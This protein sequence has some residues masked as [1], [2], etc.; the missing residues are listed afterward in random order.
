MGLIALI[1]AIVASVFVVVLKMVPVSLIAMAVPLLLGI[2]AIV[3]KSKKILGI[4]ALVVSALVIFATPFLF[5]KGSLVK[6]EVKKKENS[7]SSRSDKE[8]APGQNNQQAEQAGRVKFV[9]HK[10]RTILAVDLSGT[11]PQEALQTV[12]QVEQS[13]QSHPEKSGLISADISDSH[14]DAPTLKRFREVAIKN[15]QSVQRVAVIGASTPR[16]LLI[17]AA[18]VQARMTDRV[19]FFEDSE[20]ANEWLTTET[21]KA[22]P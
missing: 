8:K 16:K 4:V 14:I 3:K 10:D 22:G 2:W 20:K 19:S 18:A 9:N 13:L 11:S 7:S 21:G 5:Q 12:Q 17:R 6:N 15:R 1:L